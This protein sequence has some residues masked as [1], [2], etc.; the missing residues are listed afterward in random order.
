MKYNEQNC[1][2]L[3]HLYLSKDKYVEIFNLSWMKMFQSDK[4]GMVLP[5]P[6]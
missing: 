1:I 4:S 2:N 6:C 3:I 5:Q